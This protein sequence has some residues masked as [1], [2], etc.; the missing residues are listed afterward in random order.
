VQCIDAAARGWPGL[1]PPDAKRSACGLCPS[2]P[3]GKG[4]GASLFGWPRCVFLRGASRV[5][6]QRD[7]QCGPNVCSSRTNSPSKDSTFDD[8]RHSQSPMRMVSKLPMSHQ[9]WNW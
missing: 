2:R 3:Y 9:A 8:V 5:Y 4:N 6:G 1:S 7:R